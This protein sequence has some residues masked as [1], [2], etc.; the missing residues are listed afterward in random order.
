[1]TSFSDPLPPP[2]PHEARDA[3]SKH[4]EVVHNVLAAVGNHTQVLTTDK[5]VGGGGECTELGV[6]DWLSLGSGNVAI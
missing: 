5:H 2:P 3:K 1:M 6:A 4:L